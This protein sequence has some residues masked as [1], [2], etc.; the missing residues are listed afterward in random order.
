MFYYVLLGLFLT[1]TS[2][3]PKLCIN[4][5]YYTNKSDF[6]SDVIYGKCLLSPKKNENENDINFLVSGEK[7]FEYNYCST[8]RSSEDMCG[9]EG[10]LHVLVPDKIIFFKN[11]HLNLTK[12]SM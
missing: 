3:K 2:I 5:K 7:K 12:K 9:K 4:C 10:K 1:T 8:S 11:M 6:K